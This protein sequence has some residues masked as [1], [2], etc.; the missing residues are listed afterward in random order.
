MGRNEAT[1]LGDFPALSSGMIVATLQI[2]GQ[3]A[4]ENDELKMDSNSWRAK[5]PSD[6]RNEGGIL[7]GPAA[8]LPFIFLMADCSSL[9]R[10]GAQL[11][12]LTVTIIFYFCHS[13]NPLDVMKNIFNSISIFSK[14][15]FLVNKEK[16][17]TCYKKNK[18]L[19]SWRQNVMKNGHI[20][21]L[22]VYHFQYDQIFLFSRE[23]GNIRAYKVVRLKMKNRLGRVFPSHF[24]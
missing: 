5:G 18:S 21:P 4:S 20:F 15:N 19:F 1:S 17:Q 23:M 7:S 13:K 9:I 3:W 14:K 16:K 10:I 12:C 8:L 24:L 2:R 11:A 6:L 22:K